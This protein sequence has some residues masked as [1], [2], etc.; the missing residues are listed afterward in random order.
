MCLA[1]LHFFSSTSNG[2]F[3]EINEI[4]HFLDFRVGSFIVLFII[5]CV[6]TI[7]DISASSPTPSVS[8]DLLSF[9]RFFRSSLKVSLLPLFADF[10]FSHLFF[11]GKFIV[12]AVF[13]VFISIFLCGIIVV[14]FNWIVD[15]FFGFLGDRLADKFCIKRFILRVLSSSELHSSNISSSSSLNK[16]IP[17]FCQSSFFLHAIFNFIRIIFILPS[18]EPST[19]PSSWNSFSLATEVVEDTSSK[20]LITLPFVSYFLPSQM[21]GKDVGSRTLYPENVYVA[22]THQLLV[23]FVG[24]FFALLHRVFIIRIDRFFFL[25]LPFLVVFRPKASFLLFF[26][27]DSDEESSIRIQTP[28][29]S[30]LRTVACFRSAL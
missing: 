17:S 29:S 21:R 24:I 12:V 9:F 4:S 1:S 14:G 7:L 28:P 2:T 27:I 5:V 11:L 30:R 26:G 22:A 23:S 3:S 8:L 18:P 13:A 16:F 10:L 20:V 15:D 6:T 19:S 25:P